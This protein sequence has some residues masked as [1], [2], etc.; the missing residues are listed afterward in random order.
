MA[1]RGQKSGTIF[2]GWWIVLVAGIGLSVHHAPIIGFT[3]GVF[4]KS[5]SQEFSW[6]RTQISFAL[7]LANL[8]I[9]LAAPFVG[10]LVDR[11]G[12]RRVILPAVLAFGSGV[13]S[14][15]FL[16]AHLWHFYAISLF[17]GVVGSGT[18]PVPYSKI[19]SQWFDQQRGLALGLTMVGSSVGIFVM[20]SL[21]QALISSVGWRSAYVVLGLLALGITLPVV[22]LFLKETPQRMGLWPDGEARATA[23]AAKKPG[24]ESGLSS[25]E[26]RHTTTFW[27]LVSAAFLV[28]A[29]FVGC[30]IHLVPLLTDRGVSAQSAAVAT[31]VGAGGALLARA[32][33]GYLLDRFFAPHLAVYFF[34]ASA[35]GIILLWSGVVGG[36]AFVAAVLVGLGQG[37]EL[38]ILPYAISRYFGLR[39]FGEI[40]GSTFA[41][42]T[43]GAAIGPLVMGV[44]FDAT[45]SYSLALISFAVATFT[46]AGLMTRLGPYRVWEPAAEPVVASNIL[47]A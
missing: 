39:A 18:G 45:G 5:F 16:S 2:Y 42:V 37:A 29:S 34:C 24:Q 7:T 6:S 10:W 35:L 1:T 3:F 11:F 26:A 44:S 23:T 8:G 21:A 27:L 41:A 22:G 36:L 32:G 25:H 31:S 19:I 38:D 43:L 20:P 30:L 15:Y 12:A 28:S 17:M 40:Y 47:R 4:L 14:L 13:L 33:T 46:A 9:T